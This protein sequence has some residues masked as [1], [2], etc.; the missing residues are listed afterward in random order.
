VE[1]GGGGALFPHGKVE[2]IQLQLQLGAQRVEIWKK[3]VDSDGS[4]GAEISSSA[5]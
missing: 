1:V 5:S 4:L 2:R 3:T